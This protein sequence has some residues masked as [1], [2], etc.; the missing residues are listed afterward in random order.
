MKVLGNTD[1]NFSE[2]NTLTSNAQVPDY[3]SEVAEL[4]SVI[5]SLNETVKKQRQNC[6][7]DHNN[8]ISQLKNLSIAPVSNSN[9]AQL[10][11]NIKETCELKINSSFGKMSNIMSLATDKLD[12]Y[13]DRV[14]SIE[15]ILNEKIKYIKSA[16]NKNKNN[17]LDSLI[18]QLTAKN[19]KLEVKN[20][21]L[22]YQ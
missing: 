4:Q 15:K 14:A 13:D 10:L 16:T 8:T 11:E 1:N 12:I 5:R 6:Q 22:T 20:N 21:S 9:N 2:R 3:T 18:E 7:P 17:M 19:E